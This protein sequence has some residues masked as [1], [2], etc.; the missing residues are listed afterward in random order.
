MVWL[1]LPRT[2]EA[3]NSRLGL[4]LNPHVV[5][6]GVQKVGREAGEGAGRLSRAS[7]A[8]E[9]YTAGRPTDGCAVEKEG[10]VIR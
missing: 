8:H 3:Q 10:A 9:Q 2:E 7:G 6:A 5:V 1:E 4:E